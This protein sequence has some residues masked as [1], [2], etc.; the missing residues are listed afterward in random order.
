MCTRPCGVHM[1]A[2]PRAGVATCRK[3][4]SATVWTDDMFPLLFS[5][6]KLFF[7]SLSLSF[8]SFSTHSHTQGSVEFCVSV[9]DWN[10]VTGLR[11]WIEFKIWCNCGLLKKKKK[12]PDCWFCLSKFKSK[13][14]K[15]YPTSSFHRRKMQP[16]LIHLFVCLFPIMSDSQTTSLHGNLVICPLS[17]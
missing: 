11:F 7:C 14:T 2:P 10:S 12:L 4:C 8:H 6:R 1:H 13:K 16:V 9:N 5:Q 3:C 17:L 15:L